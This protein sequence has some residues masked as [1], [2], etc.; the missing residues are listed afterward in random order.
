MTAQIIIMKR[1]TGG[2]NADCVHIYCYQIS[3]VT[4]EVVL[5][6]WHNIT[7]QEVI[8]FSPSLAGKLARNTSS[9]TV[10]EIALEI[11]ELI[12]GN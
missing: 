11:S 12:K 9:Y 3:N 8:N 6:I 2:G 7:K 1:G 5:P 4:I 10:G